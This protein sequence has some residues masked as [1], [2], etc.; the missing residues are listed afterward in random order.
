MQAGTIGLPSLLKLRKSRCVVLLVSREGWEAP[1]TTR[2]CGLGVQ[3][4]VERFL[5]VICVTERASGAQL[6]HVGSAVVRRR[7]AT[8]WRKAA[9]PA[10]RSTARI[11][12]GDLVGLF[13]GKR[14]V[15]AQ[16]I[17]QAP[18]PF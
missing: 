7:A 14:K 6:P 18:R 17:A 2:L 8:I 4:P 11:S 9:L 5:L 13:C 15:Q 3:A 16:A 1:A 10:T 12:E